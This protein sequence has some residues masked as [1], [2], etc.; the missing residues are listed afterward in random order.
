MTFEK[1]AELL[2]EL[3]R[4]DG[5]TARFCL[6]RVLRLQRHFVLICEMEARAELERM[7]AEKEKND[8]KW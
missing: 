4:L 6:E 2:N 3:H 8:K 1:G 7:R 5:M